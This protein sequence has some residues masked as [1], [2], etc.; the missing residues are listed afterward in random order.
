MKHIVIFYFILLMPSVIAQ[1]LEKQTIVDLK[2]DKTDHY[3]EEGVWRKKTGDQSVLNSIR[4]SFYDSRKFERIVLDF[5]DQKLPRVHAVNSSKYKRIFLD[6]FDTGSSPKEK[7][8]EGSHF[9]K[10]LDFYRLDN[11]VLSLELGLDKGRKVEIFSL[12]NPPRL[13]IDILK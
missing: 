5:K 11:Q 12:S 8:I 9:V 2:N 6:L 13:V 10:A 7:T 4:H 1:D 3:L